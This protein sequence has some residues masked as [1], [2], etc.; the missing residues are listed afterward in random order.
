MQT[1]FLHKGFSV[2]LI[3]ALVAAFFPMHASLGSKSYAAAYDMPE[4]DRTVYNMNLDWKFFQG[5]VPGVE[6]PDF[7][8]SQWDAVSAPHT[9]ND[10]DSFDEWITHDGDANVWRGIVWYR[11]HF[12]LNEGHAGQKVMIEFEGI[13]QSAVIYVNGSLVGSYEAGVTPFGFDITDYVKFGTEDNVIAVKND[14]TALS[15]SSTGTPFQWNGRGFNPVYGGLTRNINLYI[16]NP[17]YLTL[18]LYRN[19][20]TYGTYIYPSEI[21]TDNRTATIHVE[22]QVK[23]ATSAPRTISLESVIVNREGEVVGTVSG[24]QSS[25]AANTEH[26][27]KGAVPITDVHFWQ[28]DYPYLY[29][30]Y[31]QLK[32]ESGKV[33]DIYPVTTGFRKAEF[34][35][36]YNTGGVYINNKQMYLS[37][38]AQRSTNEWAVLGNAVPEWVTDFDGQLIKSSNADFIRWMHISAEPADIRMTDKYGIVSLQPAGD[39]EKDVEGRQWEQR[40]EVMRDSIIYF[41]NSPSILFWE[42]GNNTISAEH[43]KQMRELKDQLDPHG[44]RAVG[45]R[46]LSDPKAIEYAEFVGTMLNRHYTDYARDRVPIIE[47]EY[48]RDE[49]P[50][51]V[52]DDYSPPDYGYIHDPSSTWDY[53]SEEFAVISSAVNFHEYWKDRVQGPDTSYDMY[54][55]AAALVWADSNQHGRNYLTEN[56]R[57]SGRVDAVRIPKESFYSFQVLQNSKPDLHIVGHWTYP[58]NTVKDMF[59]I[60]NHVKRVELYVNGVLKGSVAENTEYLDENRGLKRQNPFVYAFQDIKWEP[61]EIK[62]IGYDAEGNVLVEESKHTVGEPVAIKLTPIVGPE[63]LQADGQ[64]V[65]MFDVEVVDAE[66]NRYPTDQARIDFEVTGPAKFLG[67]W[68]SGKLASTFKSYIDTEAGINRVFLRST[69]EAGEIRIKATRPGLQEDSVTI[70]SKPMELEHGLTTKRPQS[71]TVELPETLPQYG[72]DVQ[73]P[74]TIKPRV[75]SSG[76]PATASSEEADR[77]NGASKGNDGGAS[78]RWAAGDG[79]NGHWWK[80]DLEDIYDLSGSEIVWYNSSRWYQYKIEVSTDDKEWQLVVDNTGNQERVSSSIDQLNAK[81]RYV[82]ITVTGKE[83][84]F[85]SFYEA[86][87]TGTGGSTVPPSQNMNYDFGTLDSPVETGYV[88]VSDTTN[89]STSR[90]YG[91]ADVTAV[92]AVDRGEGSDYLKRDFISGEAFTFQVDLPSRDYELTIMAGDMESDNQTTIALEGEAREPLTSAA[93]QFDEKKYK[94]RVTDGQLNVT[95]GGKINAIQTM[96]L[97]PEPENMRIKSSSET[98]LQLAWQPVNGAMHYNIYRAA[99]NSQVFEKIGTTTGQEYTDS[100]IAQMQAGKLTYYVTSVMEMGEVTLIGESFPSNTAEYVFGLEGRGI[101]AA[102]FQI[103]EDTDFSAT[104]AMEG[105]GIFKADMEMTYDKTRFQLKDVLPADEN[106]VITALDIDEPGQIK[107]SLQRKDAAHVINGRE[108]LLQLSFSAAKLQGSSTI[109]VTKLVI[110]NEAELKL[111]LGNAQS[112]VYVGP[113]SDLESVISQAETLY[114]NAEEGQENGMYLPGVKRRLLEAINEARKVAMNPESSLDERAAASTALEATIELFE[115]LV[116]TEASG[117][118][119]EDSGVRI[120][121][122]SYAAYYYMLTKDSPLWKDLQAADVNGNGVIDRDDLEF[123]SYRMKKQ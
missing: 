70:S 36:G 84:G 44:M 16:T 66:G 85:A 20:G 82:R 27:F 51:R 18:P 8:D 101:V 29:T 87:I 81:G 6:A 112:V 111:V 119:N 63:G 103:P 39:S 34:K 61:G 93:G 48:T 22:A 45:S 15:E 38:Y 19:M 24:G 98:K 75:I 109:A 52:W 73:P 58:E 107:V 117:D 30:V 43:M 113:Y 116:I 97:P 4:H 68:N 78:S 89:Y 69:R 50:R 12:Q 54:S 105:T 46:G 104:F 2:F 21:S 99:D 33:I 9:F 90:Q 41:R 14:N 47:S 80:V 55:A 123:I 74:P 11:K 37:G 1:R 94:V 67:G 31:N 26:I 42:A 96:L 102:P 60:A 77:G 122:F 108:N 32:D 92:T 100:T 49:A 79:G 57:M 40:M 35:G 76:K 25:I 53:N 62:A 17:V 23:N 5:D 10:V 28:P 72:P 64:D 56:A 120:G 91:I 106:T 65:A 71:M 114:A 121:D 7:D 86:R 13:R 110:A 88:K 95:V 118:V 115:G 83:G 59:V 3:V